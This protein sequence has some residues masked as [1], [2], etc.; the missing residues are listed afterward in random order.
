MDRKVSA[1]QEH[2]GNTPVVAAIAA[3]DTSNLQ[4]S[5][6]RRWDRRNE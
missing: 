5:G 6:K 1:G 4:H 3:A 2:G